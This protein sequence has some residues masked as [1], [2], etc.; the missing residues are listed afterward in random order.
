MT[1]AEKVSPAQLGQG[2]ALAHKGTIGPPL[3]SL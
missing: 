2:A 1:F 3:P